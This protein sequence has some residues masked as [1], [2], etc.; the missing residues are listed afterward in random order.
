MPHNRQLLIT[1][2]LATH[3]ENIYM[4]LAW[5]V[6]TGLILTQIKLSIGSKVANTCTDQ[7]A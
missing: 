2:W 5:H 4:P 1:N 7:T 3:V 6:D